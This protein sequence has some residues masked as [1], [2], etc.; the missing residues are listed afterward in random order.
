[1][2]VKTIQK[3]MQNPS[4]VHNLAKHLREK[5]IK[6]RVDKSKSKNKKSKKTKKVKK[7]KKA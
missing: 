4:Q 7:D 1:M 5:R 3:I 2:K 6:Q